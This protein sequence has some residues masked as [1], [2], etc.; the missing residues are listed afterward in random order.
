[1]S[2]LIMLFRFSQ[3]LSLKTRRFADYWRI[4]FIA[5]ANVSFTSRRIDT[6]LSPPGDL[7]LYIDDVKG[8]DEGMLRKERKSS[9][10][11]EQ[12]SISYLYYNLSLCSNCLDIS[13]ASLYFLGNRVGHYLN[14]LLFR[15][16]FK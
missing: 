15:I 1:M 4:L 5:N 12:S 10:L 14:N 3:L 7:L 9:L 2:L 8:R 16:L 13:R 6:E 11:R